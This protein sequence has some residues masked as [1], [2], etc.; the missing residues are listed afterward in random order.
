MGLTLLFVL[1]WQYKWEGRLA[2]L[3]LSSAF[4][5]FVVLYFCGKWR[6]YLPIADPKAVKNIVRAG[7]PFIPER[8]AIFIMGFSDRFFIDHYA[9]TGDVGYY[10]AAAQLAIIVNLTILTL[11]NAFY[12]LI[13]RNLAD[14]S[15]AANR[16]LRKVT[17]LYIGVSAI[18]TAVVIAMV[19]LFYRYFIGAHFA[20]GKNMRFFSSLGFSSGPFIT[21]SLPIY[22]TYGRTG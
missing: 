15:A 20:P 6:L 12:P 1:L 8:L 7:A 17:L 13:L 18:V 11:S 16:T 22:S 10:G 9:G 2:S 5:F 3:M 14:G 21:C 19:P 4:V